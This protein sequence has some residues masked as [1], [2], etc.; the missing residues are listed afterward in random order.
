MT[1]RGR[2][3]RRPLP[4]LPRADRGPHAAANRR[5]RSRVPRVTGLAVVMQ[6]GADLATVDFAG[7][8]ASAEEAALNPLAPA[9]RLAYAADWRAL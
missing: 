1:P 3:R 9:T 7:E 5:L 4:D 6:P 8:R 2:A